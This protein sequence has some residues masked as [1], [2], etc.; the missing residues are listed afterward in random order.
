MTGKTVGITCVIVVVV[1]SILWIFIGM[2]GPGGFQRKMTLSGVFVVERPDGYD[3]ACFGDADSKQGG[4]SC[5][6]CSQIN[7]CKRGEK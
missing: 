7:N 2:V 4:L 5:I 6:P 3:A 1:A